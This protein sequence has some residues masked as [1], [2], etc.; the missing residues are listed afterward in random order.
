MAAAADVELMSELTGCHPFAPPFGLGGDATEPYLPKTQM[1]V[2]LASP[3]KFRPTPVCLGP[4]QPDCPLPMGAT[5]EEP[6][7]ESGS[8]YACRR[9]D[10]TSEKRLLGIRI[11]SS[12]GLNWYVH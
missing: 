3:V 8:P 6:A 5:A 11:M 9:T 4:Y 7:V 1:I 2:C 12:F 10:R